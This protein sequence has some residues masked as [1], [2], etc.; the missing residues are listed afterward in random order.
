[1]VLAPL[2]EPVKCFA[3]KRY[4][5]ERYQPDLRPDVTLNHPLLRQDQVLR[6]FD[7]SGGGFAL[8]EPINGSTLMPGLRIRDL[9]LCFQ[10][11]PS[12]RC[13]VLVVYRNRENTDGGGPPRA[14]CGLVITDICPEDHTHLLAYLTHA[15]SQRTYVCKPVDM[16]ALW[17]FFFETGFIYPEKYA[18]IS[19]RIERIKATHKRLYLVPSKISRHFIYQEDGTILGHVAGI[20]AYEDSW[21]IHHLAANTTASPVAGL[22]VLR[23]VGHFLMAASNLASSHMKHILNY[24]QADKKF[25][26]RLWGGV[27]RRIDNPRSCCQYIFTYLRIRKMVQPQRI[28]QESYTIAPCRRQDLHALRR[29]YRPVHGDLMLEALDLVPERMDASTL[30]DEYQRMQL[31]RQ[32]RLFAIKRGRRLEAVC[33]VIQTEEGLN[34]SDLIN[35]IQ[36]MIMPGSEIPA[37]AL[38][39]ILQRLAEPFDEEKVT[40]MLFPHQYAQ[41]QCLMAERQYT[42]WILDTRCSDAYFNYINRIMRFT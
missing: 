20:R 7:L 13:E 21:M 42:L 22:A 33:M 24:Y 35:N 32:R 29:A 19:D 23:Q 11:C 9:K 28:P 8:H 27:T 12:I 31:H 3:P 4:R 6:A 14:R 18:G 30:S 2:N 10:D 1:L 17:H 16:D 34:L 37:A 40:V 41:E 39:Q 15:R 5:C 38:Q 36:V 26:K 25:S